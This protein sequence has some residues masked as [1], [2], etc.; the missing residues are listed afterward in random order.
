MMMVFARVILIGAMILAG[1]AGSAAR[2]G[3]LHAPVVVGSVVICQNGVA[4]EVA[5]DASGQPAAPERP[6]PCGDCA[7]CMFGDLSALTP[8]CLSGR[9]VSGHTILPE[10]EPARS[11]HSVIWLG[12]L[13]RGP[14]ATT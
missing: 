1:F 2:A 9:H 14:P 3:M 6:R 12:M 8:P 5:I 13:A 4:V 7:A 11:P 10:L